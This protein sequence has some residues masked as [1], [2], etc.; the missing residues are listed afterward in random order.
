MPL[1]NDFTATFVNTELMRDTFMTEVLVD[2]SPERSI[3]NVIHEID[4][5]NIASA[6]DLPERLFQFLPFPGAGG[7]DH[8]MANVAKGSRI[9]DDAIGTLQIL[10]SETNLVKT[11]S[12][13]IMM[14]KG[15]VTVA[16]A[17]V[18][19]GADGWWGYTDLDI[20]ANSDYTAPHAWAANQT[21]VVVASLNDAT[22]LA[23]MHVFVYPVTPP[24][25]FRFAVISTSGLVGN[26]DLD[27]LV[28][29][30]RA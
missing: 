17:A 12:S 3:Y 28:I 6:E 23:N 19:G 2:N 14:N 16:V 30:V 15:T 24:D 10:H 13:K 26:F 4:S 29:G 20:T 22:A 9:G 8:E 5:D 7:H 18:G 21:P 27:Y 11:G 1:L 25:T